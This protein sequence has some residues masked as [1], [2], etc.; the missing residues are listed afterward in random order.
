MLCEAGLVYSREKG[1]PEWVALP[2]VAAF[3]I[4]FIFYL[5]PGFGSVRA[6]LIRRFRPVTLAPW[7][8][9]SAVAPYMVYSLGTGQFRFTLLLALSG[10]AIVA[11]YWFVVF[12]DKVL[13]DLG[14]IALLAAVVLA[15]VFKQIYTPPFPHVQVDVLGHLMLIRLGASVMLLQR[16][17]G[18]IRFGFIPSWRECLVGARFF[19]YFLP[20]GIPLGWWLGIV[21]FHGSPGPPWQALAAFFGIFWVV[22]LSEEFVF[23]GILQQWMA[24][25]TGN[26]WTGLAIASL[27]FGFCHLWFRGFPNWRMAL[28]ATVA[29]AFWG[30]AFHAGRGIRAS[31]VAHALVVTTWLK[32]LN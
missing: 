11:S 24:R 9:L 10:V 32:W 6:A 17:F 5:V 23:R 29:G 8:V 7:L 15:K 26:R 4:E 31:M 1:I 3:L 22:A 2:V 16:R 19:V 13:A 25:V 21:T 30:E 27:A 14:F 18:G 20:V 28:F 12:P